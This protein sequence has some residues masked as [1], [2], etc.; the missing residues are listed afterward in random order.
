MSEKFTTHESLRQKSGRR[1]AFR[2]LTSFSTALLLLLVFFRFDSVQSWMLDLEFGSKRINTGISVENIPQTASMDQLAALGL[3]TKSGVKIIRLADGKTKSLKGRF[4]HITDIHPDPFYKSGTSAEEVCHRGKPKD[5]S[6]TAT[7]FGVAMNGCDSS[8]DLMNYTLD[9]VE[10]N[11]R[12]KIDFVVWT[13][14]NIRHDNDRRFPRTE[15]QIFDLNA[16]V[17]S[18]FEDMFRNKD[19]I[20]PRDFDVTVIPSLGNNDVFPHN[21]FSLGPTLQTR[22]LNSMWSNFIPQE[23]QRS[24]DRGTSYFV[25]VIPGKLAVLSIETLYLYKANPLVDTCDSKKEPGYQLLLWLGYVLEELRSRNMKVWLSGHVPPLPKNYDGNCFHKFTLWTNEYRDI[26][27]GGLYGHMNIDHFIPL[28]AKKS[29]K[30]VEKSSGK[31]IRANGEEFDDEYESDDVLDGAVEA[32]DARTMGAK[33]VNKVAYIDGV[34][35]AY[36]E[37]IASKAG[38]SFSIERKKKNHNKKHKNRD[39]SKKQYKGKVD[40]YSIVNVAGSVI[41][42]F[43]PSFRVWEYNISG[44]ESD[45]SVSGMP[46]QG[47]QKFFDNLEVQILRDLEDESSLSGLANTLSRNRKVDKTIPPRM[48]ADLPLGPAYVPQ[49]FTPTRFVQYYADL[50][51]IE[52]KYQKEVKKGASEEDA[53]AKAFAYKVEYTSDDAPY[54]MKSLL[55]G[56]YLDLAVQLAN[57]ETFWSKFKERAFLSTGYDD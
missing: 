50:E 22:E 13:G 23:Q 49:L 18:K 31:S 40:R 57:N 15:S 37:K 41:P 47:W 29:W 28:D 34:R 17:A 26:I 42:T 5:A 19:S 44:L 1:L 54:P 33:P 52:R 9:W 43:N 20:N 35:E 38:S 56:D 11:L 6:D 21:L 4:L 24:F 10:K 27:I 53:A 39:K 55:T 25:E 51:A 3:D 45:Y 2:L 8:M 14:D 46:A 32:S 16:K 36:Y 30:A 48:P 12:D 7:R